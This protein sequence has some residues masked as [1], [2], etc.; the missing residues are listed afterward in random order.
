MCWVFF[1]VYI[2]E[3]FWELPRSLIVF[4][5]N[6]NVKALKWDLPSLGDINTRILHCGIHN[7]TTFTCILFGSLIFNSL[8]EDFYVFY[9]RKETFS[10]YKGGKSAYIICTYLTLP[11][12]LG[13]ESENLWHRSLWLSLIAT[14]YFRLLYC[15]CG[16]TEDW[17]Q[18]LAHAS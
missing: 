9:S 4:L 11:F 12:I 15:F 14:G 18:G 7:L 13:N 5:R 10:R 1:C 3:P 17:T 16:C 6:L 8:R 2:F